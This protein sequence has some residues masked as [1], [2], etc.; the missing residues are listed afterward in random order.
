MGQLEQRMRTVRGAGAVGF[1]V[2]RWL[3]TACNIPAVCGWLATTSSLAAA[4]YL[5]AFL[6]APSTPGASVLGRIGAQVLAPDL[7]RPSSGCSPF[8]SATNGILRSRH[9]RRCSGLRSVA[10]GAVGDPRVDALAV[11]EQARARCRH[12]PPSSASRTIVDSHRAGAW[13]TGGGLRDPHAD[14]VAFPRL[15]ALFR[16]SW[17]AGAGG[18]PIASTA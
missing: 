13:T 15:S 14:V 3:L 8:R 6:R 7:R 5:G 11:A 4:V 18:P 1:I 10:V 9:H 16:E 12:G 2:C 17:E